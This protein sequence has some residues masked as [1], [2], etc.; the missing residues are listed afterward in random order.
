MRVL[1]LS[2]VFPTPFDPHRGPFNVQ[3]VTHLRADHTVRVVCPVGW[4]ERRVRH[5]PPG[6]TVQRN[7]VSYVTYYYVPRVL[8]FCRDTFMW[9]SIAGR[10]RALT[11]DWRPDVVLAYWTHPD[12]AVGHR[13]ASEL[14]VPFIQI[15]GGSDVLLLAHGLRR[16]RI[17]RTLV[18]A[19]AVVTIGRDLRERVL[20]LGADAARLVALYIP[21]PP[22]QFRAGSQQEARRALQL[23]SDAPLVLWAGRFVPVKGLDV[24]IG[25]ARRL[26]EEVPGVRVSLV[27]DGPDARR[28]RALV[29]DCGLE[30]VVHFVGTVDHDQM[31]PWFR[32]ADVTALSSFS[33]GVPNVLLESAAC[34]TPFVATRVGGVPEIADPAVD[35][36]VP[37][38]DPEAL[39]SALAAV[40]RRRTGLRRSARA[41]T[42][43]DEFR[44][45]FGEVFELAMRRSAP[46]PP[47]LSSPRHERPGT[48]AR[49]G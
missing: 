33:E 38:G 35:L 2:N 9:W 1:F 47:G 41:V 7:D 28:I 48:C 6:A 12:G 34:G 11:R 30:R 21:A 10:L 18:T 29:R 5:E 42:T 25:A 40:L 4:T 8:H 26:A 36:L 23:P 31:G 17:V 39:A 27:G 3:I 19:D 44:A 32:A 24:L 20:E 13:L 49:P 43:P 37:P 22:A 14:G 15:V 46:A 45:Q 16:K